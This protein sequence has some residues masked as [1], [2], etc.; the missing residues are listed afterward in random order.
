M[1]YSLLEVSRELRLSYKSLE[2]K[3]NI[4]DLKELVYTDDGSYYIK[5]EGLPRVL[6]LIDKGIIDIEEDSINTEI[7][8]R[9]LKAEILSL[10]NE[11]I[12]LKKELYEKNKIIESL[13]KKVDDMKV[14]E[15]RCT[16]VQEKIVFNMRENLVK[17]S[18]RNK[19]KK[20]F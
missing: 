13:S 8:I 7:E 17:R 14:V 3:I 6:E 15:E 16:K 2:D 10:K 19:K 5:E 4:E 11:S 18:E 12:V 9:A 1:G 20:W